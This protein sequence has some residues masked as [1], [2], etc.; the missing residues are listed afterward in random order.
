MDKAACRARPYRQRRSAPAASPVLKLRQALL[1]EGAHAFLLVF[2]SEQRMEDAPLEA[3]TLGERRT[4]GAIDSL[5]GGVD[6]RGRKGSDHLAD[7]ERLL[8]QRRGRYDARNEPRA[9]S[10]RRVHYAP[11]QAHLH[12]LRLADGS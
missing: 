12:G 2:G 5:L 1:S 7:L 6:G 9:L 11:R 8:H 4:V 10:L 3:H